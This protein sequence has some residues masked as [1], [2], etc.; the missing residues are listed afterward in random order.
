MSE[1][2]EQYS[3]PKE[4]FMQLALDAFKA[5]HE[6]GYM[7]AT[8]ITVHAYTVCERK[9][10]DECGGVAEEFRNGSYSQGLSD[11]YVIELRLRVEGYSRSVELTDFFSEVEKYERDA[12]EQAR[13]SRL[14]ELDTE[15]EAA[16][17]ALRI[18]IA[19]L[20]AERVRLNRLEKS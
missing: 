7:S 19:E 16:E 12:A 6:A 17:D 8:N 20:D 9:G 15:R 10:Y 13:L 11:D 18:K 2:D 14:A 3:V 4:R 1:T 5:E